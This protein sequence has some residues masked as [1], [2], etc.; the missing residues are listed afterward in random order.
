MNAASF[1]VN[2]LCGTSG[3]RTIDA[4]GAN[5]R[6]Q[7]QLRWN[8]A[9]ARDRRVGDHRLDAIAPSRAIAGTTTSPIRT[10]VTGPDRFVPR[11]D[12]RVADPCVRERL[13][14]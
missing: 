4:D 14:G 7:Q 9:A 13:L 1:E 11:S 2:A 5:A 3:S 6:L 8:R 12:E 10:A